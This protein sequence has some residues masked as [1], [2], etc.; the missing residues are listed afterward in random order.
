MSL[1]DFLVLLAENFDVD[2]YD[3]MFVFNRCRLGNSWFISVVIMRLSESIRQVVN[4]YD[5]TKPNGRNISSSQ[6]CCPETVEACSVQIL[7][8]III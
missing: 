8:Y 5:K 1:V 4:K 7:L 3:Q 6:N 2:L